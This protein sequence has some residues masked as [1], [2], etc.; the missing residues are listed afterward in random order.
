MCAFR[1]IIIADV[2][3]TFAWK[4]SEI[5]DTYRHVFW[6]VADVMTV[7]SKHFDCVWIV[8]VCW[9]WFQGAD[10]F[11]KVVVDIVTVGHS[12][13]VELQE[14]TN[15]LTFWPHADIVAGVFGTE[16]FQIFYNRTI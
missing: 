11:A 14:V 10:T 5:A 16:V 12:C 8:C 1:I 2:E 9:L 4:G 3:E 15:L 6:D 13:D 7:R